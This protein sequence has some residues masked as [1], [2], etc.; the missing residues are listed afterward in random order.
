MPG[1]CRKKK[2]SGSG[3]AFF[4]TIKEVPAMANVKTSLHKRTLKQDLK[5][6]W[7]LYLFLLP[8]LIYLVIFNYAPM[9]GVQI[10]FRNY[11]ALDGVWGSPWVGLT[12]MIKFVESY[13]FWDLLKN[14]LILSVYSLVAG[15]PIPIIF[16]L[17][18][19]N[20]TFKGYRKF[21]QMVT[22][23]PHFISTVVFCGMIWVFLSNDGI[24]NQLF[25][26]VGLQAVGFMSN[27]GSFKHIYVWSGVLQSMGFN[28]IIYISVLTA[29]SPELHEAATVDGATKFQRI[30]YIDLPHLLP[31]MVILL[32]LNM[33]QLMN[34]GFEK[35]FLLQ[36]DINLQASE[37]ISTYV[38][39][40]GIQ[41]AQFSYSA[42]IGLFNNVINFILIIAV[43]KIS[44]KLTKV[45][46]W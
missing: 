34:V 15:F 39:K 11:N 36:N 5:R 19:H 41:G 2:T 18:L 28:T 20:L 17:L 40:I 31:T 25:K 37:I 42:A 43:N 8:S 3:P 13:Q 24:I 22:Y 29:V 16:A 12:H 10:A 7:M 33:G 21:S 9:Y 45:S 26:M 30:C 1:C 4:V 23:A 32:I 38:Y 6:T 44:A 35:A 27:P 46:L 14:T